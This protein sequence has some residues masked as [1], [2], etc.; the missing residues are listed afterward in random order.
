MQRQYSDTAGRRENCQVGV[1]L[2][3]APK[4]CA[5]LDRA[6][7]LPETWAGDGARRAEAGI[8]EEVAFTTKGS[9]RSGSWT[10][11]SRRGCL[12]RGSRATPSTGAT[13]CGMVHGRGPCIMSLDM[14]LPLCQRT[15]RSCPALRK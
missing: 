2:A 3:Y 15:A 5:L 6:L 4:G 1:F 9:S 11:P 13:S 7:Y 10:A 14:G 8:P 12:R